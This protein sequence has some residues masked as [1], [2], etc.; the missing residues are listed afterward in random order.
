MGKG[1]SLSLFSQ[2]ELTLYDLM[3]NVSRE[4]LSCTRDRYLLGGVIQCCE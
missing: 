4:V 2:R 1:L 3:I